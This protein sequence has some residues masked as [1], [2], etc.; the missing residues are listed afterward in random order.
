MSNSELNEIRAWM[1]ALPERW[2]Y[3]AIHASNGWG[4]V[5]AA[6]RYMRSLL[7]ERDALAVEYNQLHDVLVSFVDA[8]AHSGPGGYIDVESDRP[9]RRYCFYCDY[10][11]L[12]GDPEQHAADCPI[13]RARALLNEVSA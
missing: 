12:T 11:W 2:D 8:T 1:D 3:E 5:L 10:D 4:F 13:A 7:A 9:H 6:P